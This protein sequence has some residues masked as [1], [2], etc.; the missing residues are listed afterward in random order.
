MDDREKQRK[1]DPSQ[2]LWYNTS[3]NVLDMARQMHGLHQSN[4][5]LTSWVKQAAEVA[6]GE[7]PNAVPVPVTL[8]Q[9]CGIIWKPLLRDFF[10]LGLKFV[11]ACV[12][13]E[14]LDQTL[15]DIGDQGDGKLMKLELSLMSTFIRA[16]EGLRLEP[17]WLEL[18][19]GQIQEYRQLHEAAAAASAVLKIATRMGLSGD[20]SE[21]HSLTQMVT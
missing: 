1:T 14:E 13:F 15:C 17:D 3:Q 20:F 10:Q 9:V 8:T 12:T 2:V 18:R 11:N 4:L 19:L 21:I 6:S 7:Q 5:I 16:S